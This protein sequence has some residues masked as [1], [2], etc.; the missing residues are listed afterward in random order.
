MT[1]PTDA[2]YAAEGPE[3]DVVLSSRVRL[4]RNL[5]GYSFPGA[6]TSDDA[7]SV[8]S[9]VFDAFNKLDRAEDYQ[10]VRMS[11]LDAPGRRILSE[12]G[13]IEADTGSEP[14]RAVVVR[15]DGVVS[16]TVNICDHVRVAAFSAGLA[17]QVALA[18][19]QGIES[20]L[21]RTVQFSAAE[22]LGYLTASLTDL[23][24]GMKASAI[25]SLPGISMSGMIDRVLRDYLA[26][27]FTV[28][29]Y[30][31]SESPDESLGFLYQVSTGSSASGDVEGQIEA[32]SLAVGKLVEFER[33]SRRELYSTRPTTVEDA[34]YRAAATAKYARFIGSRE[35]VD[36]IHRI[37]L[38]L[39]LGLVT[40]VR[41]RELTALMYRVQN[42]HIT[43]VIMG[44]SIIIEEDVT[45]EERRVDRLRAM[46]IQEVLK[47]VDIKERR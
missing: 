13:V 25:L 5:A 1:P 14:W 42:A 6:L 32:F 20:A 39:S 36:L 2:W 21:R 11:N 45:G 35:A 9:L 15:G 19:A 18:E 24:T 27:G 7:E 23:G 38:G 33:R 37:K 31:G 29:G 12:R 46:V 3:S 8:Q 30:Y 4:A 34:V 10:M 47:D 22:D 17:P 43:F 28:R 40:G 44:G 26:Q 41:D 16:A